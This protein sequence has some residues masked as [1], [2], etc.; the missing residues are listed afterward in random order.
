MDLNEIR[1][2]IALGTIGH[3]KNK[4]FKG[5]EPTEATTNHYRY[6]K[7]CTERIYKG[8]KFYSIGSMDSINVCEDCSYISI[9]AV[10]KLVDKEE[11]K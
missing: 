7:L 5:L 8:M 1:A 9:V 6:C 4:K 11:D 3:L 2:Q 10:H